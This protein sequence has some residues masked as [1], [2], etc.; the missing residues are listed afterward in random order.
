MHYLLQRLSH[1]LVVLIAAASISFV[2]MF[3]VGDPVLMRV[4]DDAS[5]ELIDRVRTQMGFDR[6]LIVQYFNY[7]WGVVQGDFGVSY[8]HREP[9]LGLLIERL[10]YSAMLAI[11]ALILAIAVSIPVGVLSAMWRNR[12]IDNVA[13]TFAL[14]GQ[15]A[16][17]FWV[18]IILILIFAIQLRW[19]PASGMR[20]E[21]LFER[22]QYMIMPVF[23]LSLLTM[24][25]LTR[26][27]RGAV[28]ELMGQDFVRTARAKGLSPQRV[29]YDHVVRNAML[30]YVT[31][32]GLQLGSLIS[33]SMVVESVFSWPGFGRFLL[34]SIRLMDIPVV[35]GALT[36]VAVI[37]VILAF[38]V[39]VIYTLLDPRLR[40]T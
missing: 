24:A 39:D 25:Y 13:R 6:P 35:A 14:I 15:A 2:L 34:D 36:L 4:G 20:G 27:M 5:Q 17:N 28:L 40:R 23:T 18:G 31:V 11:P 21:T 16:P 19:L 30:P 38:I 33:G 22:L 37:Y 7:M 10:G 8:R 32:S 9:V 3:V 26:M 12:L 29:M 1:G